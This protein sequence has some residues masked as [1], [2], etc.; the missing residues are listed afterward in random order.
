MSSG[1]GGRSSLWNIS[2]SQ[3]KIDLHFSDVS[4]DVADWC[5]SLRYACMDG[6]QVWLE[7]DVIVGILGVYLLVNNDYGAAAGCVSWPISVESLS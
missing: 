2:L 3:L 6:V 1:R 5:C 4:K 7:W